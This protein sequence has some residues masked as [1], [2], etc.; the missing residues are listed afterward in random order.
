M[1]NGV[2]DVGAL[3]SA[4]GDEVQRVLLSVRGLGP[5][6][7]AIYRLMALRH[8]D[9]WPPGDLALAS[10]MRDVKRLDAVPSRGEQST[11]AEAW[12]PWRSVAARILWMHYLSE[13]GLYPQGHS[14]KDHD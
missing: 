4:P 1:S 5:W 13:R 8:V 10:A 6:T 11:I 2:L 14:M 12:A 7:V 3:E 9:I